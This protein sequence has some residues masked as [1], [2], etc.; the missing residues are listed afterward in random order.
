L[1][2]PYYASSKVFG[3]LHTGAEV[4]RFVECPRYLARG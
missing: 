4:V 3:L 2:D 1:C